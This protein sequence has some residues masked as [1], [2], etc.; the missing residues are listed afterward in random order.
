M[1]P[2]SSRLFEGNEIFHFLTTQIRHEEKMF[3]VF[4]YL[5]ALKSNHQRETVCL[6]G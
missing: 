1:Q 5:V 6:L 2:A 4:G 3:A